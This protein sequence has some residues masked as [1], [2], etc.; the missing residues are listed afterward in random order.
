[1]FNYYLLGGIVAVY[2]GSSMAN[3]WL[4][5]SSAE[6]GVDVRERV[7]QREARFGWIWRATEFVGFV[8]ILVGMFRPM[9]GLRFNSQYMIAAGLTVFCL[10]NAASA[11]FS[12][13]AYRREAPESKASR[14]AR[15]AAVI[16]TLAEV[17]LLSYVAW[18]VAPNL[19]WSSTAKPPTRPA[20]TAKQ[21]TGV[22]ISE[23][24]ALK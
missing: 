2:F 11:W 8:I 22:W 5:D 4:R 20:N 17:A 3:G 10:S 12:N 21:D 15:R 23:A 9:L 18:I 13:A 7:F 24:A 6:L 16:V 14:T 19:G 1:M